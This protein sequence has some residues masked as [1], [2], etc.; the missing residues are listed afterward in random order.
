MCAC[1]GISA[2]A[3]LLHLPWPPPAM[4]WN[5]GLL[6]L[7]RHCGPLV[8][9]ECAAGTAR[10]ALRSRHQGQAVSRRPFP[11]YSDWMVGHGPVGRPV[12]MHV[13]VVSSHCVG[14]LCRRSVRRSCMERCSSPD[15]RVACS[16]GSA[17]RHSTP[18]GVLLWRCEPSGALLEPCSGALCLLELFWNV[19]MRAPRACRLQD[20][21][22]LPCVAPRGSVEAPAHWG[23]CG[24]CVLVKSLHVVVYAAQ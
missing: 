11:D 19:C 3:A 15:A 7:P 17:W 1:G 23:V 8:S 6:T 13:F 14:C 22:R 16:G 4:E 18:S 2:G 12:C 20:P 5:E 24:Q 21:G 10:P 9:R